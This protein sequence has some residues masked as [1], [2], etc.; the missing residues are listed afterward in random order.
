M[1]KRY[2]LCLK[3]FL[4]DGDVRSFGAGSDICGGGQ[5]F[6]GDAEFYQLPMP[7]CRDGF[8]PEPSTDGDGSDIQGGRDLRVRDIGP[9]WLI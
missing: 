7:P 3:L 1:R 4:P 9:A 2:A 8:C 6:G 5:Q